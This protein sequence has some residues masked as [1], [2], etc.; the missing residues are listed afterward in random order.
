MILFLGVEAE[1]LLVMDTTTS[2]LSSCSQAHCWCF[3]PGI[4]FLKCMIL[5]V[6]FFP[7]SWIEILLETDESKI[8]TEYLHFS[9][10]FHSVQVLAIQDI[11]LRAVWK[12]EKV[13]KVVIGVGREGTE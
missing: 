8:S 10:E 3:L 4:L 6:E 2:M 12:S 7:Q 11:N 1:W 13:D 5:L 9:S